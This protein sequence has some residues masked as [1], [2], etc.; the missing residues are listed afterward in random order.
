MSLDGT[1]YVVRLVEVH[2]DEISFDGNGRLRWPLLGNDSTPSIDGALLLYDANRPSSVPET[3]KMLGLFCPGSFRVS[4]T[5][6]LPY[7]SYSETFVAASVPFVLVA[8]KCDKTSPDGPFETSFGSYDI[9]RTSP[10]SPQK[11]KMC[12]AVILRDVFSQREGK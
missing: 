1:V 4:L 10:E 11:Q 9:H 3:S 7:L 5:R 12:I 8:T 2:V 6:S